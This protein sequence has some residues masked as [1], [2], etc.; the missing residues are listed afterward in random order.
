MI[1]IAVTEDELKVIES[2]LKYQSDNLPFY[3]QEEQSKVFEI[4]KVHTKILFAC[5]SK[6]IIT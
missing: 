5:I 2:A 6:G 1:T 3:T 4:E